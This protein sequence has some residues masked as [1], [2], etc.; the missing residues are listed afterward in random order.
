MLAAALAKEARSKFYHVRC[1]D[2]VSKWTGESENNIKKLFQHARRHRPADIFFDEIDAL[3][4]DWAHQASQFHTIAVEFQTQMRGVVTDNK[5]ILFL[6]ATDKPW[7]LGPAIRRHFKAFHYVPLP[8]P[9]AR[10]LMFES[11]SKDVYN[12]DIEDLV[13]QTEGYS[14]SD[15]VN[16]INTARQIAIDEVA[17]ASYFKP[18]LNG[19]T[20]AWEPCDEGEKGATLMSGLQLPQGKARQRKTTAEDFT[21]ALKKVNRTVT[22]E[23]V[24]LYEE[25]KLNSE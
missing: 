17:S 19:E 11:V 7:N 22:E 15:I 1:S 18:V 20:V 2:I 6:G 16:V 5:H 12:L 14:G 8:D 23:E 24:K 10:K 3:F 4:R 13:A 25:Y 21:F 9:E